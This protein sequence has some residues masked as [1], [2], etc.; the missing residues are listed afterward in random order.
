MIALTSF[1]EKELVQDALQ[2]GAIGYLL[3]ECLRR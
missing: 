1:Q 2:A 3:E